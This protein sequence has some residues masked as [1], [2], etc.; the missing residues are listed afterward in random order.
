VEV[1][2]T[3]PAS[4]VVDPSQI[5]EELH[6]IWDSFNATNTTRACLFNLI[7]YTQKDHRYAYIQKLADALVHK[8]PAR[9]IFILHDPK[10]A[11]KLTTSVSILSTVQGEFDVACDVIQ[12]EAAGKAESKIPF[13]ILPHILPDLPVYLIFGEDPSCKEPLFQ[14]LGKF[15]SRIIFD[16]ETA[17]NLNSFATSVLDKYSTYH[18]D[19]ADLNWARLDTW[20]DILAATFHSPEKLSQLQTASKL[21]LKYNAQATPFFCHTKIQALYLQA[22]L[23]AQLGWVFKTS[24]IKDRDLI[25]SYQTPKG[26]LLCKLI[27]QTITTL[28][29]GLILSVEIETQNL[30]HFSFVTNPEAIQEVTLHTSTPGSCE[31]PCQ[32]LFSKVAL[33]HSLVNEIYHQG[34]SQHF[35]KML[36]YVQKM[37]IQALC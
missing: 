13:L 1:N 3:L 22:W 27:P 24:Q 11:D 7:F 36:E 23:A 25:F 6:K 17:E 10:G 35:L 14:D 15:A 28:P 12:I 9:V 8:F 19:I 2:L 31:L 37:D 32:F 34:T 29:P 33:G 18:V 20:R 26:E 30:S 16:S 4:K 21:T 5:Q